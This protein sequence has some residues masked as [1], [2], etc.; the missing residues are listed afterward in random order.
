MAST[1]KAPEKAYICARC[2]KG[3]TTQ[4]RNFP[5]TRSPMWVGNNGY[6]PVCGD[7]ID[8]LYDGYYHQLGTMS[9]AIYRL[10]MKFDIYFSDSIVTMVTT[11]SG[12]F[13]SAFNAYL[14]KSNLTQVE[15]NSFDD[16]L[17]EQSQTLI[18]SKS[19]LEEAEI[20]GI[21]IKKVSYDRWG[22][23]FEPQEYADLDTHYRLLTGSVQDWGSA[24]PVIRNLCILDVLQKRALKSKDYDLYAK[25][26]AEYKKSYKDAGFK[27]SQNATDMDEQP[28][29]VMA[30]VVEKIGPAE[31]YKDKTLFADFD[32]IAEY[33]DRFIVRPFRNLFTGSSDVDA[34]Y[35]IGDV[36]D[37]E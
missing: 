36:G 15:F 25:L 26:A 16:T 31:Y 21:K 34:Q 37:A 4:P 19:D 13:K 28:L 22:D 30:M 29:G 11:A 20:N 3:Y 33:F 14:S 23:G 24:W 1:K 17:D 35:S 6:L 8:K 27:I 7:C 18:L 12:K 10:C 9:E 5:K 2:G 32:K